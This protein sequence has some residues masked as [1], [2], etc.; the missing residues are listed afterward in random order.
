[1]EGQTQLVTF[2]R[3]H[4]KLAWAFIKIMNA[5][6]HC[7][8]LHND[9]SKA[10]IMLYFP[11]KKPYVVYIGMCDWG[12]FKRLQETPSLYGFTKEQDATN[13]KKI[14]GGLPLNCFLFITSWELQ[15]PFDEWP[16]NTPQL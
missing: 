3:N 9:L 1:M 2:K 16:S 14:D 10:N 8:I 7:G 6:N 12:E 13:A 11:T 5:I 4:V 15:I